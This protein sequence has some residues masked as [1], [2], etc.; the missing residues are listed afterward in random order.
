MKLQLVVGRGISLNEGISF[1]DGK[2]MLKVHSWF[3]LVYKFDSWYD[4]FYRLNER[5]YGKYPGKEWQNDGTEY[6]CRH[7]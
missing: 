1:F 6:T 5:K 2:C 3:L 7:F 4:I